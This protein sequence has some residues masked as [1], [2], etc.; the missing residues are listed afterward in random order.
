MKKL[1]SLVLLGA[2]L[3]FVGDAQAQQ[4]E[5]GTRRNINSRQRQQ[6]QRIGQGVR[7]GELTRRETARLGREQ[8]QIRRQE[9]QARADGQ[10]T[11]LERAEIHQELNQA[12]RRIRRTK[13]NERDRD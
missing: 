13:R 6:R 10:Y 1:A 12:S 4:T 2:A 5:A 9:R 11:R 8:G 7:S 3:L